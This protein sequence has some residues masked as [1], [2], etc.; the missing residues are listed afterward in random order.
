MRPYLFK[1]N[2][3][4]QWKNGEIQVENLPHAAHAHNAH[5]NQQFCGGAKLRTDDVADYG[6][7]AF[8]QPEVAISGNQMV[9]EQ[10]AI[11]SCKYRG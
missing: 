11:K 5:Q 2:N 3:E 10:N 8:P 1:E 7:S 6:T 4:Y 9:R